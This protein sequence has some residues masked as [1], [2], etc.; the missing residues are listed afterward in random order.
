[1]TK[2]IFQVVKQVHPENNSH[3]FFVIETMFT[4]DGMRSRICD[5]HWSTLEEARSVQLE[6]E[7]GSDQAS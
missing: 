7:I 3:P 2:S 1:M 4:V 6:Y 5:G